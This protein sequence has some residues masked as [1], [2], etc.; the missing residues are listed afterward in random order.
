MP[1][2]LNDEELQ[3][4]MTAAA[5]IQRK[6]RAAFLRDVSA[7]LSKYVELGPGIVSRVTARLQRQ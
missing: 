7:E 6:D 4:V 5:P 3:I 2:A 1:L